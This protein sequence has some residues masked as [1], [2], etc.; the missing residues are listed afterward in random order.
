MSTAIVN[1]KKLSNQA[2][3]PTRGSE[4]AA[5]YDL[6]A[7]PR[8]KDV[9]FINPGETKVIETG[10]S[11]EIPAGTFGGVYPRSGLST[12]QGL[13]CANCVGVVDADYRGEIMVSLHNDSDQQRIVSY[14]DRI[15]QL[16]VQPFFTLEFV[17]VDELSDTVRG[18]GGY[19]STGT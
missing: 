3:I 10:L 15:A 4:C 14:G 16:I 19:G 2:I 11:M 6:Y 1:F 12:K 5:G 9:V 13:R 18:V 7:C 8:G 17:E